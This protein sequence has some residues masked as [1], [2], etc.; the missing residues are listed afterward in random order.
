MISEFVLFLG[1]NKFVIVFYYRSDKFI[2]I[3]IALNRNKQSMIRRII[4]P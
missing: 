2:Q 3:Y 4:S 1:Y